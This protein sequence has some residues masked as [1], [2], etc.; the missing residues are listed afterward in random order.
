MRLNLKGIKKVTSK[1]N[2]Y[3]YH[4]K[5]G[6]RLSAPYGS[7]EFVAQFLEFEQLVADPKQNSLPGTWGYLVE[8]YK[9]S[10]AFTDL[11]P[12]TKR[13]YNRVFDF[14]H[15]EHNTEIETFTTARIARLR[16]ATY[17]L[18]KR[19]FAN[20]MVSVFSLVFNWAIDAGLAT[21]NPAEKVKKIKRPKGKPKANRPWT[22]DEFKAMMKASP[23]QIRIAI[24]LSWFT[25]IRQGDMCVLPWAAYD[26][27]AININ[28]MKTGQPLWVPVHRDLKL[29]L[30]AEK[31]KKNGL[32]VVMNSRGSPYTE[33]GFRAVFFKIV[34]D[35]KEKGNVDTGLT[36][37]GLRTTVATRLAEAGAGEH[38][39]MAVTG[40]TSEAA[41]RVYT[42]SAQRTKNARAA[43]DIL[44]Q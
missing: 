41:V 39:I 19:S 3:Y 18:K 11:K 23:A 34:R 8:H 33:S 7:A 28:Q 24:A 26:G 2:V 30:D 44:E 35:Q 20:Y 16:D 25:G 12:R 13:D 5:T 43:I 40:H 37:H 15:R 29:M 31:N 4:R 22:E 9:Q 6:R 32:Y 14:L 27:T 17:K 1:G 38:V 10:P 42:A 36:Y 21:G